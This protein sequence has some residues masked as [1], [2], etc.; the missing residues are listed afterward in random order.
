MTH[1]VPTFHSTERAVRIRDVCGK[2]GIS[3]THLYR[4]I[5]GGKFPAP[6]R[7]SERV[8]VWREADVDLWLHRKFSGPSE[9][10]S[11][12]ISADFDQSSSL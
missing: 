11:P 12:A 3:R 5:A 4:L 8:S 7:I 2:T 9:Q 6:I 1:V 10:A